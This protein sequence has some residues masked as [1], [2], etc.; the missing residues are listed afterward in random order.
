[1]R[2]EPGRGPV[3]EHGKRGLGPVRVCASR[4][5]APEQHGEQFLVTEW[6]LPQDRKEGLATLS[7][8]KGGKQIQGHCHEH[9]KIL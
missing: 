6:G 5:G 7:V 1:M 2:S 3:C 4:Q 8:G 9:Q